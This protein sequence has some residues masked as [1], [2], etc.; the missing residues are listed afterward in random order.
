MM[1]AR[2]YEIAGL[3]SIDFVKSWPERF[4]WKLLVAQHDPAEARLSE[5]LRPSG[6]RR[7]GRKTVGAASTSNAS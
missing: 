7:R 5:G 1:S 2:S 3:L 4:E 6:N